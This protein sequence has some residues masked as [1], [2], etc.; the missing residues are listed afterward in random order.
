M[1]IKMYLRMIQKGWWIIVLAVLAS[2][3]VTLIMDLFSSPVYEA[4]TRM[5][6]LPN[7]ES[8]AGK[9]FISSLT[10]LDNSSIVTTYA[11]VF[12]S[13]F[14]QQAFINTLNLTEDEITEY[15]QSTVILPDSNVMEIYVTGPNPEVV[16]QWAN[17]VARTGIDYMKTLYQ[18]YEVNILDV[19]EV[20]TEPISPK[21]AR[22]V[23][24]GAVLGL[25]IG[26]I[27]AILRDQLRIPL[28]AYRQRRLVDS[29]STAFNREYFETLI[30]EQ[31]DKSKEE[32][33]VF[34]LVMIKLNGLTEFY[35]T[36]P[37]QVLNHLL[38]DVVGVLKAGLRGNDSVGRWN[39]TTFSLLL[40]D[41]P[42]QAATTIRSRLIKALKN[43]MQLA[44]LDE[45]ISLN[46]AIGVA[47]NSENAS[48]DEIILNALKAAAE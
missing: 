19:A 6:V 32:E 15:T 8:F 27:L 14:N 10:S 43:P 21:P 20:P 24:L 3:N 22:D 1:N 48:S 18:V 41:T 7:A 33:G 40:P 29:Q 30:N 46:P 17:G 5:I 35:E 4:V 2:M 26:A 13:E 12:D 34:S 38:V 31:T 39:E 37:Q 16:T 45:R 11:D 36:L 44:S 47:D 28:E 25:L 9:D 42:L 23:T